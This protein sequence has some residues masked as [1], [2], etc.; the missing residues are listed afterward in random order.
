MGLTTATKT[1]RGQSQ[2]F[3]SLY[4]PVKV[5]AHRQDSIAQGVPRVTEDRM[6]VTIKGVAVAKY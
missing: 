6:T 4:L 1:S 5:F 2:I 3:W